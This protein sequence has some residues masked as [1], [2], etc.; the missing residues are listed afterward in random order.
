MGASSS[1]S[2]PLFTSSTVTSGTTTSPTSLTALKT[3]ASVP[4]VAV[5]SSPSLH[6][7]PTSPW[8]LTTAST[9]AASTVVNSTT[10]ATSTGSSLPLYQGNEW[11]EASIGFNDK[12]AAEIEAATIDKRMTPE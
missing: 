10:L 6:P 11:L 1:F 8:P 7:L 5:K 3:G 2:S 12:R 4:T 9:F